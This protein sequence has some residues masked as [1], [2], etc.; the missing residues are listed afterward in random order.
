MG[1]I[2]LDFCPA[3]VEDLLTALPALCGF[4]MFICSLIQ[5]FYLSALLISC[6][7]LSKPSLLGMTAIVTDG[8]GTELNWDMASHSV[9]VSLLLSFLFFFSSILMLDSHAFDPGET[10]IAVV[11][12]T[13]LHRALVR[14]RS[15]VSPLPNINQLLLRFYFFKMG[16]IFIICIL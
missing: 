14:I 4:W 12:Y 5:D 16:F 2:V 7:G 1:P 11:T 10:Q 8:R 15:C 3:V 9:S 6:S 13:A